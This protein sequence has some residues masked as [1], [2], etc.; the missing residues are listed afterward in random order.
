MQSFSFLHKRSEHLL[1]KMR[2]VSTQLETYI[3]NDVWL[4]NAQ[5]ANAMAARLSNG[6]AA[7]D[8]IELAY[9]TQS[10]EVF[11]HL[12]RQAIDNL[13]CAGFKVTKGELDETAPSR[14]V[15]VWNTTASE[16]DELLATAAND[17][18]ISDTYLKQFQVNDKSIPTI[19]T[20]SQKRQK[21][22]INR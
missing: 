11:A 1:S 2:F 9:P 17:G 3:S 15:T 12:S 20:I 16:V 22:D 4:R 14:F 10:N 8:G 19:L 5:H 6:F 13:N 21:K 18:V 7:I